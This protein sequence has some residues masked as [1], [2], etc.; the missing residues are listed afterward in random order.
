MTNLADCNKPT[1][2][3]LFNIRGM[4]DDSLMPETLLDAE[5]NRRMG[6]IAM[7]EPSD[8]E[9]MRQERTEAIPSNT[10][11]GYSKDSIGSP[12]MDCDEDYWIQ[13]IISDTDTPLQAEEL[14]Y[15]RT[16]WQLFQASDTVRMIDV[17]RRLQQGT[18][19]VSY[20]MKKLR[21]KGI[22]D[23]TPR[24]VITMLKPDSFK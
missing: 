18:G 6:G 10:R 15:L 16:I 9:E 4:R 7:R 14:C 19:K 13:S 17:A 24:G 12:F 21:N 20:W 22:I 1:V 2:S 11:I 8:K 23:T 3:R 5:N